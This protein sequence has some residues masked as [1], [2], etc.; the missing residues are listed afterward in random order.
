[1]GQDTEQKEQDNE[2]GSKLGERRSK[3][4]IE[5]GRE[6]EGRRC[7]IDEEEMKEKM[8]G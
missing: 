4:K 8:S 5:R 3:G 2:V 6:E 7:N 1:V